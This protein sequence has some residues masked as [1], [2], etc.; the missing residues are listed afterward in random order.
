M[1]KRGF[2]EADLRKYDYR[3]NLEALLQELQKKGVPVTANTTAIINGLSEQHQTHQLRYTVLVDDGTKTY[4]PPLVLV[5]QALDELLML[6][7]I[8]THGV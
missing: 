2:P 6:T 3:H 5:F 8:S 1:L 7:R 4:W